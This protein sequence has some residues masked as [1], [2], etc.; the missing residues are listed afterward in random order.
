MAFTED[1]S[2]F[3]SDEEFA[4]GALLDGA[5]VT[6]MLKAG[7]AGASMEGFGTAGTSPEFVLPA[8]SVPAG[9]EGK[10]F[11]ISSGH[12]AGTYRVGNAYPD[13]TGLV[14]LHLLLQTTPT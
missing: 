2:G 6:G 12:A 3:F 4:I 11:V 1:F 7:F 5:P 9:V 8:S 13:G 14:T 10:T